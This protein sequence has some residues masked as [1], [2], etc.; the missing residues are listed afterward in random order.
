MQGTLARAQV[1]RLIGKRAVIQAIDQGCGRCHEPGGCGGYRALSSGQRE[2]PVDNR[3]GAAVGDI[4]EISVAEG[5]VARL[6][7]RFYLL[8]LVGVIAGAVLGGDGVRAIV[9]AIVG[10][11]L[12]Y[13]S[14]RYWVR[15]ENHVE[16]TIVRVCGNPQEK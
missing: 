8:P 6:A 14:A 10:G 2:F 7:G 9:G 12:G 15:R 11:L 16:P 1:V 3:L 4:V 13:L 5:T